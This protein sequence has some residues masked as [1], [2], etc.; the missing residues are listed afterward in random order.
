MT[1][2]IL[3]TGAAGNIGA[4]IVKRLQARKADFAVM[5]HA[6]GGAPAGAGETQGDFLDPASLRRAFE[7]VDTLFLLFPLVPEMPRM[8]ANAV[9]A[10]K[11]A[12][13][14][15]IV[16][17]SG[18]GAD[19]ASPAAIAKVHGEIDALIRNS[20]IPFTLLL[21]TSF[22]QNLVNFY[23]AA[24]RDGAL[25][26]PRGDGAT[27][28]IDV[29]DIADVAVEVLTHPA[30]HAGQ[31][32]TLTGP[33]DLTDAQMVSAIARQIGR[34][35]RYVDVPETAAV[36]SL[37]RMGSPPQV[38]EWLMSLNHVIKQGWAAGVSP[39]VETITGRPPRNL[40]D[41]VRE[42]AAAW[43]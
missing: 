28:V 26:A 19:A 1:N 37:T 41:F 3:V 9:A 6:S 16:R 34:D 15:H 35:V 39:V 23:G 30:A 12:G 20:G 11:A 38:I 24:I 17:S 22:M 36:D 2:R 42:N 14:R 43:K 25:Y 8:A 10:A 32:Y 29:R 13:V 21:P 40:A 5:T 33:E 31:S 7:G 4:E 18:A 27:A